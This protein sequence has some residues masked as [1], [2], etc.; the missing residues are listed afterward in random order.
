MS[1]I[2]P[3]FQYSLWLRYAQID[4]GKGV[5]GPDPGTPESAINPRTTCPLEHSR[6]L[7]SSAETHPPD[8]ATS[9]RCNWLLDYILQ[10]AAQDL[11]GMTYV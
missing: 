5:G 10:Q 1:T 9:I 2:D 3:P 8:A 6:L 11:L 7:N 4:I